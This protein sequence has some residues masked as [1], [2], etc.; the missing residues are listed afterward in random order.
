MPNQAFPHQRIGDAC[1]HEY[2]IAKLPCPT[3][4]D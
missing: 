4:C 2:P 3:P 1:P